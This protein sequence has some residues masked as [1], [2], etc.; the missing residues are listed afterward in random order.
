MDYEKLLDYAKSYYQHALNKKDMVIK[1]IYVTF[2]SFIIFFSGFIPISLFLYVVD[3][4]ENQNN[5]SK[6]IY[7]LMIVAFFMIVASF[8]YFFFIVRDKSGE[9]TGPES[10]MKQPML[11]VQDVIKKYPNIKFDDMNLDDKTSLEFIHEYNRKSQFVD[12]KI[13]ELHR[14]Y[15]GLFILL[16]L[17]LILMIAIL[18]IL[19]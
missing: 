5:Y 13:E 8:I 15:N 7:T 16:S 2:F 10:L 4:L 18:I 6:T 14:L 17:T 1:K 11:S 19:M 9:L 12:I 3:R